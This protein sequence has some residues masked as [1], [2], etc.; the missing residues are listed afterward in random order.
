MK[1]RKVILSALA[2]LSLSVVSGAGLMAQTSVS[3][4]DADTLRV[5]KH[6]GK[7]PHK[8][9]T[10]TRAA[11]PDLFA[12]YATMADNSPRPVFASSGRGGAPGK[13]L[14]RT[15]QRISSDPQEIA[16][17]ARFEETAAGE[18]TNAPRQW[19]G[20]PGKSRQINR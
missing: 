19:R 8:R 7:P 10:L 12:H 17:F 5:V 14:P 2:G 15:A 11:N 18:T 16:E 9:I 13:S 4:V 6:Q 20:A 3:Q 1:T